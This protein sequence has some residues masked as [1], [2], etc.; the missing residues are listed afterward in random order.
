[1]VNFVLWD[2]DLYKK[3]LDGNFLRCIDKQQQFVGKPKLVALPL[4]PVVIEESFQQ[5]GLD[6]IGPVNPTSSVGH[7]HILNVTDYFTKWVEAI[8]TKQ[9]TSTMII[10]FCF[11]YGITLSHSFDYY[12]QG[13]GQ[14]E[15]SN[16]NLVTIIRKLF[17]ERQWTWH[18]ALYDVLWA[19]RI[20]PKRAIGMSPFQLLYGLNVEIPI[21]LELLVLKLSK[22]VEDET[23]QGSLDKW[24]MFLSQL[25]ETRAEVVDRIVA[26][27]SQVKVLFDKKATSCE[28]I[29]GDQVLLWDKWREPK[30]MHRKLDSLWRGPF[31]IHELCGEHRYFLAYANGTTFSLPHSG[32]HLKLFS[33]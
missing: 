8:S 7:M 16:K 25:E 18:K 14:V 1:M 5:W 24:I 29:V 13:N 10:D 2:N 6:F 11:D 22:V 20:T 12:P 17:D 28:F 27:Q 32:E 30:D 15:S 21:T 23:Y 3:G 31:T 33:Q 9:A 26:H 4:K 19:D